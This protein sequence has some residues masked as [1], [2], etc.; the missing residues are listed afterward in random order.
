MLSVSPSG[1]IVETRFYILTFGE[2]Y[3]IINLYSC[4]LLRVKAPHIF[5]GTK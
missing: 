1:K 4:V 2:L 5:W 3:G